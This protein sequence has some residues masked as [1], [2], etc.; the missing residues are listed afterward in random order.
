VDIAK[1]GYFYGWVEREFQ[2]ESGPFFKYRAQ[3]DELDVHCVVEVKNFLNIASTIMKPSDRENKELRESLGGLG[4]YLSCTCM[5]VC[6]YRVARHSREF[7]FCPALQEDWI[8]RSL[9]HLHYC[10]AQYKSIHKPSPLQK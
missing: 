2:N 10:L 1:W 8:S 7:D 5:G 4:L 3:T 6:I 9:Q